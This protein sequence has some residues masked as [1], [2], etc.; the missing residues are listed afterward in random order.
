[1]VQEN[2]F[3]HI[4]SHKFKLRNL[5][6]DTGLLSFRKEPHTFEFSG[7]DPQ[8]ASTTNDTFIAMFWLDIGL[9]FVNEI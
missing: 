2:L 1:M 3:I 8:L 9:Q 5:I 7:F 6:S 4:P